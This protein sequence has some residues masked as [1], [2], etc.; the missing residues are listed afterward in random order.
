MAAVINEMVAQRKASRAM[1]ME[2]DAAM[3][4]HMMS[5]MS[6]QGEKGGMECPMMKTSDAAEPTAEEKKPKT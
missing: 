2:M 3:M 5:H 1:T 6:M 4:A